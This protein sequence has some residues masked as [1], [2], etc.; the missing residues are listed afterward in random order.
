MH[1]DLLFGRMT[2]CSRVEEG[3]GQQGEWAKLNAGV[4]R[5]A[6]SHKPGEKS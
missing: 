1:S 6:C 4:E 2:G 3:W 5:E